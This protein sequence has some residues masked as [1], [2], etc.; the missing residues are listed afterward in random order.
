VTNIRAFS[1]FRTRNPNNHAAAGLCL[2]LHGH[3]DQLFT[4]IPDFI[5]LKKK[6]EASLITKIDGDYIII[7]IISI[8][9]IISI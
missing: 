3:R 5:Q 9:I 7:I 8:S 4:R 6:A 2:R 1:S